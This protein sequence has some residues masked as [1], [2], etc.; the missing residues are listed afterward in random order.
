[1]IFDKLKEVVGNEKMHC[2]FTLLLIFSACDRKVTETDLNHDANINAD[3]RKKPA[4]RPPMTRDRRISWQQAITKAERRIESERGVYC[5]IFVKAVLAEYG[6]NNFNG[7]RI[8]QFYEYL[9]SHWTEL[10]AEDAAKNAEKGLPTIA[11]TTNDDPPGNHIVM[12]T[13]GMDGRNRPNVKG[14]G[15]FSGP[16]GS[17]HKEKPGKK[18]LGYVYENWEYHWRKSHFKY[19]KYFS[20]L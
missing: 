4:I 15:A 1:M 9:K 17:P 13:G 8:P 6:I 10:S 12:L 5:D 16:R 19:I 20:R 2:L 7:R 3:K 11:L 18:Y 14:S